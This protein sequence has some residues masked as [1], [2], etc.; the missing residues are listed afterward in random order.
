[1]IYKVENGK[2]IIS[3]TAGGKTEHS[4]DVSFLNH[5]SSLTIDRSRVNLALSGSGET[6]KPELFTGKL[7]TGEL[8]KIYCGKADDLTWLADGEALVFNS[9]NTIYRISASGDQPQ[10]LYKFSNISYSP[11]LLSLNPG[12]TKLAFTKWDGHLRNICI[13]DL[14]NNKEAITTIS[15]SYYSWLDDRRIIYSQGGGLKIL[16]ACTIKTTTFLQDAR[17]LGRRDS[18]RTACGELA[19]LL[20]RTNPVPIKVVSEPKYFQRRIF[21]K[22]FLASKTQEKAAILSTT[23]N[24]ADWCQHFITDQGNIKNY[25]LL[26]NGEK[27]AIFIERPSEKD[28]FREELLFYKDNLE[29]DCDGYFPFPDPSFPTALLSIKVNPI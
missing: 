4:V 29:V 14:L 18:F 1:M 17:A 21:F 7:E 9:G 8:N 5:I 10:K 16:D 11:I 3:S 28:N 15:C 24:L 6:G 12:G 25:S 19:Q 23:S 26:D 2:L 20:H 22:V 27:M 13:F